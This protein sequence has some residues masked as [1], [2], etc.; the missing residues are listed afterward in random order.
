MHPWCAKKR[1]IALPQFAQEKLPD[2]ESLTIAKSFSTVYAVKHNI[3][4]YTAT[5]MR[6]FHCFC[7]KKQ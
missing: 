4:H 5:Y 6:R 2:M 3:L 7:V 1:S